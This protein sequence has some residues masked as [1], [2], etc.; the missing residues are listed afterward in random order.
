[1]P[2][3]PVPGS[4]S[5]A[6]G[7]SL[8]AD[9]G[10]WIMGTSGP[11]TRDYHGSETLPTGMIAPMPAATHS[12]IASWEQRIRELRLAQETMTDAKARQ[13][14]QATIESYERLVAVAR[15]SLNN[16]QLQVVAPAP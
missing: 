16:R 11:V 1:M 8:N 6:V 10:S 5:Q 4:R 2:L 15:N 9:R 12:T 3:I 14:A 7:L 13:A